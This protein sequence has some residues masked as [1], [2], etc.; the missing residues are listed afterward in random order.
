MISTLTFYVLTL[1]KTHALKYKPSNLSFKGSAFIKP[2]ALGG[3]IQLKL[4][5]RKA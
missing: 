1:A 4:L 2:K 5:G 3:D